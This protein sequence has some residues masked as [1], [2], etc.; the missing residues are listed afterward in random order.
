MK[1][2]QEIWDAGLHHVRPSLSAFFSGRTRELD[3][4]KDILEK[5]GSAVVT[6]YRGLG[7]RN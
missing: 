6:Q 4:L 3:E 5:F 7:K 2:Q 1:G